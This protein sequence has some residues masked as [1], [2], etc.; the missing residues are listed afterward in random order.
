MAKS[1]ASPLV[2]TKCFGLEWFSLPYVIWTLVPTV[3]ASFENAVLTLDPVKK[4]TLT[5]K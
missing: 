3:A 1:L 5:H 4:P 2:F